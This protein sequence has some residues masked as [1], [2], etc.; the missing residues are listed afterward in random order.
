M[1]KMSKL[2]AHGEPIAD[3]V[4]RSAAAGESRK[5]IYR[6]M[7]DG[8]LLTKPLGLGTVRLAPNR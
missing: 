8:E 4:R 6:L 5:V 7:S 2:S 3:Y 1:A